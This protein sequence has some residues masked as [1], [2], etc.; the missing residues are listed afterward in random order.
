LQGTGDAR[1]AKFFSVRCTGFSTGANARS[2][3]QMTIHYEA[4]QLGDES[5]VNNEGAGATSLPTP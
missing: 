1:Y 2:L 5:N 3:Q 4:I